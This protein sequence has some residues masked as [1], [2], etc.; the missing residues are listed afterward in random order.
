[1]GATERVRD[2][3]SPLVSDRGLILYDLSQE[4]GVLTVLVDQDGG[5]D[6]Q[7]IAELT[8]AISRALDEHDPIP[9]KYT[10]EV[11][12]PGLERPLRRREHFDGALDTEV[13]I[14]TR[15]GT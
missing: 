11:S 5:I 14:K 12:S 10:L 3:V 6:L 1:M 15:P 2:L 13:T 9:G 8:R 4:S 7:V